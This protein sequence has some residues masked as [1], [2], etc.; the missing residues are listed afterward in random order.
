MQRLLAKIERTELLQ[1]LAGI[2]RLAAAAAAIGSASVRLI[3]VSSFRLIAGLA[4]LEARIDQRHVQLD[5]LVLTVR[6]KAVSDEHVHDLVGNGLQRFADHFAVEHVRLARIVVHA[7]DAVDA[8][9]HGAADV[10]DYRSVVA[11][12][13][14]VESIRK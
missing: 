14:M 2:E 6:H 5:V 1:N 13:H 9:V 3:T 10:L 8:E 12:K 11:K 4:L 7:L